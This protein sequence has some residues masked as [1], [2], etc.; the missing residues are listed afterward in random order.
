VVRGDGDVVYATGIDRGAGDLWYI[1]R[2]GRVFRSPDD[3]KS[4]LGYEQRYLGTARLERVADVSSLRVAMAKEEIEIGDRLIPAPRGQLIN[5]AP[6]PP[7]T[8]VR[9]NVIAV[10]N[11]S[12]EAGV[13]WIVTI[14]KG[15]QDG[16]DVGTVL[17]TFR[18]SPEV[19]D[20]RI[21]PSTYVLWSA[22]QSPTLR[23]PEERT[24]LI[25][26]FLTFDRVSYAIALRT[27]DPILAGHFFRNP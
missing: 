16:I 5:Y 8:E 10:E 20:P 11:G 27:S 22:M 12:N 14:D 3:A 7:S 17:A 6:H 9:G 26:V 13:G 25:F 23:L 24:G 1:Y 21:P 4:V 2:P 19:T 15:A 18:T